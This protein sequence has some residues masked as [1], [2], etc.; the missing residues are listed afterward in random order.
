LA[1]NGIKRETTNP[2]T[3]Q[4]NGVSEQANHTINNL[5]HSMIADAHEVLK[6]K[7]LPPALWSQA[8]QHAVWIKNC[9]LTWS[10]NS[11]ITLYQSYFGKLP[12]L[13]TLHLFGCK[14]YAHIPKIDQTKLGECSIE[15][16]HIGFADKKRA[17]ILYL[18]INEGRGKRYQNGTVNLMQN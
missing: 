7:S 17:Y 3:P 14:A 1:E 9:T 16:I 2:Y 18:Y 5:A 15:C 10:L 6:A 11:K 13:A 4:E 8:V 12:S